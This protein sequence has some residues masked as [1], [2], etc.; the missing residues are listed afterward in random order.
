MTKRTQFDSQDK[1]ALAKIDNFAIM[2]DGTRALVTG[3]MEIEIVRLADQFQL[4][5]ITPRGLMYVKIARAE[6]MQGVGIAA[7]EKI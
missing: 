4:Q 6:L 2:D 5:I 1:A 3:K 7:D